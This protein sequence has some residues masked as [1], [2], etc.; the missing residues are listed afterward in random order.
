MS[1]IPKNPAS[2]DSEEKVKEEIVPW[3]IVTLS[4]WP[5]KG[6]NCLKQYK[7]ERGFKQQIIDCVCGTKPS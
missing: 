5:K 2:E 4:M 7:N 3:H 1:G 6:D